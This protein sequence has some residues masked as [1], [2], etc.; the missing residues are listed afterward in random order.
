M[1]T[2]RSRSAGENRFS[3]LLRPRTL[4]GHLALTPLEVPR[5]GLHYAIGT[6][7]GYIAP[8]ARGGAI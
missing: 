6:K 7:E 5:G 4:L 8:I 3:L 2:S 1:R